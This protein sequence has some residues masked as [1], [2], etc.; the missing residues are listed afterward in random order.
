[1]DP[2]RE[3]QDKR[4]AIPL[5]A[6]VGGETTFEGIIEL[7]RS[8]PPRAGT[9][10]ETPKHPRVP[11]REMQPTPSAAVGLETWWMHQIGG[12]IMSRRAGVK[13]KSSK[14]RK[15]LFLCKIVI[16][17]MHRRHGEVELDRNQH[18]EFGLGG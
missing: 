1:M 11:C 10:V 18:K 2:E 6:R 12:N 8:S 5:E 4:R 16:L 3:W 9:G 15:L 14:R 7:E 17:Q 13:V